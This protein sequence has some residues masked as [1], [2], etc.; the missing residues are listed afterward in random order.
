MAF[1]QIG[2]EAVLIIK[3]FEA[4]A[5]KYQQSLTAM[6]KSTSK[7]AKGMQDALKPLQGAD[8]GFA[9]LRQGILTNQTALEGTT[10]SAGGFGAA[11]GALGIAATT[12]AATIGLTTK[13]ISELLQAGK[14]AAAI[15]SIRQSYINL[16]ASSGISAEKLLADMQA[17]SNGTVATAEIM[18]I[19][20][21]AL[22]AGG[23]DL[24]SELPRLFEIAAAA[25]RASGQDIGYVFD[26]LVKG[27]VKGSPLLID[28]AEIYV[29]VGAA[30]DEYAAKLG[31]T[32]DT[33]TAAEKQQ[34][35]LNAVLADGGN[36]L[37]KL[38]QGAGAA[39]APFA[40][41]DV[42]WKQLNDGIKSIFLPLAQDVVTSLQ[43]W[44]IYIKYVIAAVSALSAVLTDSKSGLLNFDRV[45]ETF[46]T[47]FDE[48]Y[49]TLDKGMKPVEDATTGI[50]A[51]GDATEKTADQSEELNKKLADLETQR[52][53]KLADI[54]K[55]L[56]RQLEDQA[57]NRARQLEDAD[58][59]LSRRLEDM[60]RQNVQKRA[61]IDRDYAKAVRNIDEDI[62][63]KRQDLQDQINRDNERLAREHQ[64]RLFDI[65]RNTEDDISEAA[66]KNDAV[67]VA[68]RLREQS[69]EL[70]DERTNYE[71]GQRDL[72]L[73][74][75]EKRQA[76][77]ADIE[78]QRANEQARY[79]EQLENLILAEQRQKEELDISLARQEE[80]R[81]IS[82]ARQDADFQI[83]KQRRLDDLDDWY[84]RELEKLQASLVAQEEVV[85]EHVKTMKEIKQEIFY[86][87][88]IAQR[89]N[90]LGGYS[91][92]TSETTTSAA[93]RNRH[94]FFAEGGAIVAD[95]PTTVT[96][97]EAGRELG[98][99][100]P[101]R[102]M[103]VSLGGRGTIGFEGVP[104]GLTTQQA[105][106]L[107]YRA[108]AN[109]I[110]GMLRAN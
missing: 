39:S 94:A 32:A 69:R 25:A 27:I 99:F 53:E 101:E 6:E 88:V 51:L 26:T 61:D 29:K 44:L 91:T 58:R 89:G 77:E 80:D 90:Y 10:T 86:Q 57:T 67:A 9:S 73:N 45:I 104:Q 42:Q 63:R 23:G 107:A 105:Q 103:N 2:M 71:R 85:K 100:V 49:Q 92:P 72:D 64:D 76:L 106:D 18:R 95:K 20:N 75:Q 68:Q 3:Q 78:Q 12:V 31:K 52:I 98:V 14:E 82:W 96:M 34:A 24:A 83:A 84:A 30:V 22:L 74:L 66:R 17:V 35:T 108:V 43:G 19:A 48:T 7:T 87:D 11:L 46:T 41:L 54:D 109:L 33:L 70:R 16:A 13:A 5:Q 65:R 59:D 110:E 36:F 1:P 97:G 102:K 60:A 56:G 15:E 8:D 81:R 28:N 50:A 62:A 4:N 93:W 55:Q 40:Q 37:D 79:Q 21:R 47:K 38:G